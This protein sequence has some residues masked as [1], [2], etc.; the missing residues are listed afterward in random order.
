MSKNDIQTLWQEQIMTSNPLT[1]ETLRRRET[2]L[3]A[4]IRRRNSVEYAIGALVSLV[5]LLLAAGAFGLPAGTGA[6]LM[7]VGAG[8]I[9]CGFALVGWHLQRRT[10]RNAGEV[11]GTVAEH[12]LT[13]LG[14]QR[15]ALSSVWLWYLLPVAP[16][17]AVLFAGVGL[18]PGADPIVAVIDA[19]LT[20]AIFAGIAWLNA[21]A[22]R[23]L[24]GEL[25]AAQKLMVD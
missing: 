9:V 17:L 16:G 15:D 6:T 18:L 23:R 22:A 1:L 2:R 21:R 4:C 19:G 8:L 3:H 20:A 24:D 11:T 10:G 7:R 12:Y 5:F 14:R 13:E 25:Q